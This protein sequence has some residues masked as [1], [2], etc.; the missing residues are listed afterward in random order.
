MELLKHSRSWNDEMSLQ[1]SLKKLKSAA[2]SIETM[3][4]FAVIVQAI[5]Y[6]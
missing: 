3:M 6:T 5:P 1:P 4:A 2:E